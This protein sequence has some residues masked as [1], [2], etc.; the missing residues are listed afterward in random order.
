LERENVGLV[1]EIT[2]VD[3]RA[4]ERSRAGDDLPSRQA[5]GQTRLVAEPLSRD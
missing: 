2:R 1:E 5:Y 4:N 3:K